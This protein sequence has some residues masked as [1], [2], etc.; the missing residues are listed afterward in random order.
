MS[1]NPYIDQQVAPP[2]QSYT[3]HLKIPIRDLLWIQR[4]YQMKTQMD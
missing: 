4:I 2:S 1:Q 3:L